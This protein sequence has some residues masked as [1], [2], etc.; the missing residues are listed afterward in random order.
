MNK[1]NS[2]ASLIPNEV[3]SLNQQEKGGSAYGLSYVLFNKH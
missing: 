3:K 2:Q 1:M